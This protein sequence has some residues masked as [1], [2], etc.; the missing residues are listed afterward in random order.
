MWVY[1]IARCSCSF[2]RL[3]FLLLLLLLLLF[4]FFFF[5]LLLLLEV[6]LAVRWRLGQE[7]TEC[8]S[9][10][11]GVGGQGPDA[12]CAHA[13]Y[14]GR[15]TERTEGYSHGTGTGGHETHAFRAHRYQIARYTRGEGSSGAPQK[16]PHVHH[17]ARGWNKKMK[18]D[19]GGL[20]FWCRELSTVGVSRLASRVSR[21]ALNDYSTN[22]NI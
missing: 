7:R 22:N 18:V 4:F 5:L 19:S 20:F 15:R 8:Q 1:S 9:R 13:S 11:T 10:R 14:L 21:L 2:W 17:S 12:G 3:F 6:L 16:V